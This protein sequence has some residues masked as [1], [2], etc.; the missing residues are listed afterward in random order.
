M[1]GQRQTSAAATTPAHHP[2]PTLLLELPHEA[3]SGVGG[4]GCVPIS[5]AVRQAYN[6]VLSEGQRRLRRLQADPGGPEAHAVS[7]AQARGGQRHPRAGSGPFDRCHR[8]PP[9]RPA[10]GGVVRRARP[11]ARAIRRLQRQMDRGCQAKNP[12]NS[13]ERGCLEKRGKGRLSWKHSKRFLAT[14]RHYARRRAQAGGPSQ[15]PPWAPGP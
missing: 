2:T 4:S 12:A 6:A 8:S 7:P 14:R 13:D 15:E 11:D 5:Q 3:D 9:G 10:P 1:P